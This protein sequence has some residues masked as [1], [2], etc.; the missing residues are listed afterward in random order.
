MAE[1]NRFKVVVSDDA[2]KRDPELHCTMCG[3]HL[4]DIEHDDTLESLVSVADNHVCKPKEKS[5]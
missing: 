5:S 3:E 1:L 2:V 4:C